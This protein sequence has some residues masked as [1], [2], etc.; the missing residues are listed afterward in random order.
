MPR[1]TPSMYFSNDN[2]AENNKEAQIQ[3][4]PQ[5]ADPHIEA[6]RSDALR[7]Y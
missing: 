4:I 5:A 3:M 2:D 7:A 1:T 6:D